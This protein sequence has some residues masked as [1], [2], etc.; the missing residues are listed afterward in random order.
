MLIKNIYTLW[1][2]KRLFHCVANFGKPKLTSFLVF[3]NILQF[4]FMSNVV[5]L[6]H[7]MHQMYTQLM[8]IDKNKEERY[9][10]LPRLSDTRYSDKGRWRYASSKANL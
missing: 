10:R 7:F 1:G 6:L 2:R 3:T 9:S 5:C 8:C 4:K